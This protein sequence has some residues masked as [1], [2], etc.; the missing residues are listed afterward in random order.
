MN[1]SIPIFKDICDELRLKISES[2]CIS[3]LF[4]KNQLENGRPIFK[5]K[6]HSIPVKEYIKYLG[7]YVDGRFK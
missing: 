4:V 6:Q 3:M 1:N 2:K 7:F 5:I